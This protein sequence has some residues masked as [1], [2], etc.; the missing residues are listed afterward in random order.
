ME[1]REVDP[2]IL[3]PNP[4]NPRHTNA[5]AFADQQILASIKAVGILQP[6][7]VREEGDELIIVAGHRRVRAAAAIPLP[8]ILVLVRDP[9]DG[10][11]SV[12]AVSENV[13]RAPLSPVDQ[14]RAIEALSSDQWTDEAIG[15]ALA[16]PVR[17]IKKLRLLAHIHPAMLDYIAKGDMP[18][19]EHLRTISA[20]S[21]DEQ[22]SVWKKYKPKKGQPNV[23]WWEV[24]HALE[25]RRIYAKVAKFGA[26][27]ELAFGIQWE[28][29]LFAQADEDTRYTTNVEGFFAAQAAWMEATLPKNGVVLPTDDYGHQKLPPKAERVWGQAKKSDAIGRSVNP[30]SG[31]IDEVIF[32]MPK[33]DPKKNKAANAADEIDETPLAPAKPRPEITQKGMAIIGDLRTEALSTALLENQFDDITLIGVLLLAFNAGN[34]EIKTGDYTRDKRQFLFQRITEGGRLTQDIATLRATARETL[35]LILSCRAGYNTSGLAARFAGDAIGADAH[36]PNMA[37]EEILSCL[38]KAGIER[39]AASLGVPPKPRA[40]DTRAAL[41]EQVGEGTFV[42][43]EAC[44]APKQDELSAHQAPIVSYDDDESAHEDAV[45]TSKEKSRSEKHDVDTDHR[46]DGEDDEVDEQDY[47]EERAGRGFDDVAHA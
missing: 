14:W 15:G 28:D 38:S 45:D 35:A 23:S 25:K 32:R 34:V 19:E 44:F 10:A 31:E 43:P 24:A 36:L 13:V 21:A 42:L 2:K 39:A 12:R 3:I 8:K 16:L 26:D 29:D 18:K 20:A 27:E 9:D 7:V 33:P 41:I 17:T 46:E 6:P 11:D 30:R 37:K 47:G 1:L 5:G 40:K 4:N 22:A